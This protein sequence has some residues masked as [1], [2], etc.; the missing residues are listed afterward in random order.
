MIRKVLFAAL[1]CGAAPIAAEEQAGTITAH[2][3][4]GMAEALARAGYVVALREDTGGA[5]LLA[6]EFS[7]M[8]SYIFF[9][10]CEALTQQKCDSIQFSTGFDRKDPWDAAG[11]MEVSTNLRFA[12]V[13]LDAEGDPYIT[14]DVITGA[15]IPE[16]I[17]LESVDRFVRAVDSTA[18]LAFAD[19]RSGSSE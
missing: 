16:N 19:E 11:A 8:P 12:A 5:P 18:E 13:S 6:T 7:G 3:P 9:Y 15:G 4:A 2:D 10:D 14:W 17:F 1:L